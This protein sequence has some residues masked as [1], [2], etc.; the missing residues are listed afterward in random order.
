L[1]SINLE[2]DV[3][4]QGT[5]LCQLELVAQKILDHFEQTAASFN[6]HSAIKL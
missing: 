1:S 6:S 5:L 4:R 3:A 2:D